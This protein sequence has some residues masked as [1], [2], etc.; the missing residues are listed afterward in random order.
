M[1]RQGE[2]CSYKQELNNRSTYEL[3]KMQPGKH[4][5]NELGTCNNKF[6]NQKVMKYKILGYEQ[7]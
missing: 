6:R 2:S 4:E 3:L 7:L 5:E 1:Q